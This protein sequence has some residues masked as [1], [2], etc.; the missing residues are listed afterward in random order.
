MGVLVLGGGSA[1]YRELV[2]GSDFWIGAQ[3]GS[4]RLQVGEQALVEG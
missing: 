3:T 4:G 1:E 2:R